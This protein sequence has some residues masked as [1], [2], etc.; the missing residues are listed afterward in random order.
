MFSVLLAEKS[1]RNRVITSFQNHLPGC[2]AFRSMCASDLIRE[3][4]SGRQDIE[5]IFAAWHWE[6]ALFE[7]HQ[8]RQRVLIS[9]VTH[10][11]IR[12][13]IFDSGIMKFSV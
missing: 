9:I 3:H 10:D 8:Q 13:S 1:T 4:R 6:A 2:K 7:S 11:E 5:V 12:F